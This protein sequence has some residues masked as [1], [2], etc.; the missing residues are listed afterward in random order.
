AIQLGSYA[1]V[2]EPIA[3]TLRALVERARGTTLV[4]HDPTVRL[5]VVPDVG[6]WRDMLEWMLPRTDLLKIS[7]EDLQL[8]LPGRTG[9]DFAAAALECGVGLVVVTRGSAGAE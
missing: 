5:N 9:A 2:V 6:P 8:L 4:A 1:T 3:S 7:D